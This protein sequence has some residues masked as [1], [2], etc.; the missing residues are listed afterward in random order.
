MEYPSAL[1]HITSRGNERKNIFL[2]DE[3]R[4]K[5]LKIIE[6]YHDRYGILIHSYVLMDNHYHLVLETLR[7]NLLKIMHGINSS[8]TGYFNRKYGRSGH[9]FQGRYKGIIVE[10]DT[11]LLSL[12]RYVHLNPVRAGV[13]ERPEYY[14]WSSYPGYIGKQKE[15]EWV[16]YAWV[17]SQFEKDKNVARKKYREYTEEGLRRSEETPLKNLYGQVIAGGEDFI[18]GIKGMLKGKRLTQGIVDRK[19]WMEHSSVMEIVSVVSE[20]FGTNKEAIMD[21][22]DR[23]NRAR[24]VAIYFCQRYAGL[25]N[26]AIGNLFVGIHYSTVSKVVDRIRK[27]RG[28]DK[29]L[30]RL[31]DQINSHFKA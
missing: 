27:E 12:S 25:S 17:L 28:K 6:D 30:S 19:R 13:V 31:M 3:D 15:S 24:K 22:G 29:E 2:E 16:D 5:F 18:R 26:E 8:Y 21:R 1:Y 7:G 14:R 11:Y 20:A 10:K 23:V 9:L 4:V